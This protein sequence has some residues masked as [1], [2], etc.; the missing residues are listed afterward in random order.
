MQILKDRPLFTRKDYW[1]TCIRLK[2]KRNIVNQFFQQTPTFFILSTG[3][4]ATTLLASLLSQNKRATVLHEPFAMDWFAM[5]RAHK[6]PESAFGYMKNYRIMKMYE[7]AKK[8]GCSIYGETTPPLL[9]HAQA[10]KVSLPDCRLMHL[11]RDGR[12]VVTSWMNRGLY[13]DLNAPIYRNL[14]PDPSS[15]YY[16]NWKIMQPFSRCCWLWMQFNERISNHVSW[17]INFHEIL[18]DYNV[19]NEKLCKPLKLQVSKEIW[20][21]S[22]CNPENVSC[23]ASFPHH[24]NWPQEKKEYFWNICGDT[25]SGLGLPHD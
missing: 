2:A 11:V 20:S 9:Y 16:K 22:V 3:R 18:S 24:K 17:R 15:P 14:T 23:S 5:Y 8:S 1:K 10:L 12:E 25:M 21:Q 6:A 7:T 4:C 19:F 13:Q